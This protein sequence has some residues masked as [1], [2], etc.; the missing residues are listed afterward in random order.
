MRHPFP[1]RLFRD[2]NVVAAA[3]MLRGESSTV[4]LSVVLQPN[5]QYQVKQP[6]IILGL[7]KQASPKKQ[8]QP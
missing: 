2:T 6:E 5:S 4:R 8:A 1:T 3:A 7:N